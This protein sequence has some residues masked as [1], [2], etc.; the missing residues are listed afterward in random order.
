MFQAHPITSGSFQ[1]KEESMTTFPPRIVDLRESVTAIR[2]E[3]GKQLH[4]NPE[5]IEKLAAL[6]GFQAAHNRHGVLTEYSTETLVQAKSCRGDIYFAESSKGHWLIGINA[7][8]STGGFCYAPS[9][10]HDIGFPS[11]EDARLAGILKLEKFFREEIESTAC[12]NTRK[13][14]ARMT[15]KALELEKQPQLDLFGDKQG[16]VNAR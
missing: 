12:S 13:E 1:S 8:T 9:A 2:K 11:Y 5:A 7:C 6:W 10:F 14:A 4:H 3:Y 16:G 15:L